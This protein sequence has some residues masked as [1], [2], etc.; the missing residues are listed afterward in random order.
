[1]PSPVGELV[2]IWSPGALRVLE[3][4]YERQRLEKLLRLHYGAY[5]LT[6]ELVP[7]ELRNPIE[8][9]FD[10]EL[11]AIDTIPVETGGTLFQRKTWAALRE[12]PAGSTITYGELAERI[13]RRGACRAVGLANGANPVSIVVP[14]HRVIGANGALTG[15]G[16]GLNRKRWLLE[17]ER[18]HMPGASQ[19]TTF[20]GF[21]TSFSD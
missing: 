2:L 5:R 15:Y 7:A 8:A 17:H 13:G 12:I 1:M 3:F 21:N 9:Y 16:G 19:Q 4:D 20:P 18:A 11:S 10:G 6:S 14:C